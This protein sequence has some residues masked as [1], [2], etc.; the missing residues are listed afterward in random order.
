[1]VTRRKK[2]KSKTLKRKGRKSK[3]FIIRARRNKTFR[4]GVVSNKGLKLGSDSDWAGT[5]SDYYDYYENMNDSDSTSAEVIAREQEEIAREQEKIAKQQELQ[6]LQAQRRN[7]DNTLEKKESIVKKVK[8]IN[9]ESMERR[10][11][12]FY[13]VFYDVEVNRTNYNSLIQRRA[14]LQTNKDARKP[15]R[16]SRVS[17]YLLGSDEDDKIVDLTRKLKELKGNIKAFY[18]LR[19]T[20]FYK[21]LVE[22]NELIEFDSLF[23]FYTLEELNIIDLYG[24]HTDLYLNL[25]ES[26]RYFETITYEDF[27][28][29]L[30]RIAISIYAIIELDD[31]IYR[32]LTEGDIDFSNY[33]NIFTYYDKA[34]IKYIECFE[35]E[36][37]E[38]FDSF[39]S[40]HDDRFSVG[41]YR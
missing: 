10:T 41:G 33:F 9:R 11:G 27:I 40:Y 5:S 12:L 4:G 20:P 13:P 17:T 19:F 35:K 39:S 8:E 1:M 34:F 6:L 7:K 29:T 3:H 30:H 21:L 18:N 23:L 22:L 31:T 28:K 38:E 32:I 16:F 36:K 25:N 24:T 26:I 15:S 37:E 14:T 2:R